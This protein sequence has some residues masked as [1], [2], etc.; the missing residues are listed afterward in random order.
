MK[1]LMC[2]KEVGRSQWWIVIVIFD[3][4]KKCR[5]YNFRYLHER[6]LNVYRRS[7]NYAMSRGSF[8][9][10]SLEDHSFIITAGCGLPMAGRQAL[11]LFT[12]IRF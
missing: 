10:I 2:D 3:V 4:R 5:W 11:L 12:S 8:K 6:L 7:N 1:N 9:V